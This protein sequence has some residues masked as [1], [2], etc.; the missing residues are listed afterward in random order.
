[1]HRSIKTEKPESY[2][3]DQNHK[4]YNFEQ[5]VYFCSIYDLKIYI[6]SRS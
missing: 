3:C 1:M 4:A 6:I 5:N 2:K